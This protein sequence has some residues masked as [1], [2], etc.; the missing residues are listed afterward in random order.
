M[1]RGMGRAERRKDQEE[2]RYEEIKGWQSDEVPSDAWKYGSEVE[3]KKSK[4]KDYMK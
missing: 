4:T 3:M 1:I 2:K